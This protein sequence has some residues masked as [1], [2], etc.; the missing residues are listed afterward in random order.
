MFKA[1][2]NSAREGDS[3]GDARK[4]RTLQSQ[5]D[6]ATDTRAK[7]LKKGLRREE[8]YEH[9]KAWGRQRWPLLCAA[10]G[11]GD[12]RVT[13]GKFQRPPQGSVELPFPIYA[14]TVSDSRFLIPVCDC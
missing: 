10:R 12:P 7:Y 6:R 5:Y 3:I 4:L 1:A 2:V 9:T 14:A 13:H 8:R 11:W